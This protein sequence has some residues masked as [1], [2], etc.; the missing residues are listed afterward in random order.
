MRSSEGPGEDWRALG[1]ALWR[2]LGSCGKQWGGL[3]SSGKIRDTRSGGGGRREEEVEA[4]APH[5]SVAG[6]E[7]PCVTGGGSRV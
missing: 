7:A 4:S 1:R 5:F 3:W 2:A 6:C